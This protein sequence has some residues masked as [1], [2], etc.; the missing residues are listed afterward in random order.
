MRK[1]KT[2]AC[3]MAVGLLV[4]SLGYA[5]ED[6][7]SPPV[8][9]EARSVSETRG[10]EMS[11]TSSVVQKGVKRGTQLN[12]EKT[13]DLIARPRP[14]GG[15]GSKSAA[16]IGGGGGKPAGGGGGDGKARSR[17]KGNI[18]QKMDTGS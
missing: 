15:G 11:Q 10:V 4:A 1:T 12:L 3:L 13:L 17:M 2:I 9:A 5:L 7:G 8:N 14:G 6:A 18:R 16:G